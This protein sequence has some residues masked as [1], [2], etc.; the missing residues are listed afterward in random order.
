M[1]AKQIDTKNGG[2]AATCLPKRE[3]SSQTRHQKGKQPGR[4]TQH[5][6]KEQFYTLACPLAQLFL[7]LKLIEFYTLKTHHVQS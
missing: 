4:Q 7:Y 5:R 1:A 2:Q 6:G 3:R